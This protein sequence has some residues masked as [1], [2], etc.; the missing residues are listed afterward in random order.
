MKNS[1]ITRE[2]YGGQLVIAKKDQK[3][4]KKLV[5]GKRMVRVRGF[6]KTVTPFHCFSSTFL[7]FAWT[8]PVRIL[9]E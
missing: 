6:L 9:E 5:G 3:K 2:Q 8:W 7:V 4:N 1:F